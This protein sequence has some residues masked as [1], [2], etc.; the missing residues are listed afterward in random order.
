MK[1]NFFLSIVTIY[2]I[3]II[4]FSQSFE[5]VKSIGSNDDDKAFTLDYDDHG[6]IYIMGSFEGSIDIDPGPGVLTFTPQGYGWDSFL[7]K[8]DSAGNL[9]WGKHFQTNGYDHI[10]GWEIKLDGE[11]NI[12]VTGNFSGTVDFD[13]NTGIELITAQ[14][15]NDSFIAKLDSNGSLEWVHK[16]GGVNTNSNYSEYAKSLTI[17]DKANVYITGT[18]YGAVDFDPGTSSFIMSAPGNDV[19]RYV[20][21]LNSQGAFRW[22]F[23][24]GETRDFDGKH[25]CYDNNGGVLITGY[26][27]GTF[28]FDPGPNIFNLTSQNSIDD[29]FLLKVDTS[30]GFQW[31][32]S[33]G[34]ALSD[35]LFSLASD[36]QGNAIVGGRFRTNFTIGT[37]ILIGKIWDVFIGKYDSTGTFLWSGHVAANG[38]Y[39]DVSISG[40]Q[41]DTLSNMYVLGRFKGSIDANPNLGV[42]SLITTNPNAFVLKLNKD[43]TYM[44]TYTFGSGSFYFWQ[45]DLKIDKNFNTY[46]LGSFYEDNIDFD[47]GPGFATTAYKNDE[48]IF[49]S[50]L[51]CSV[52]QSAD[53]VSACNSFTW[54]DGNTYTQPVNGL[55]FSANSSKGC[56]S[57][58][59][60]Y[61]DM[62]DTS[63][64]KNQNTLIANETNASYQWLDCANGFSVLAGDTNQSYTPS[65]SGDYAVEITS[66]G[67]VDTSGCFHVGYIDIPEKV[68]GSVE[69]FPNPTNGSLQITNINLSNP[70]EK[71]KVYN[72]I[73]ELLEMVL[74]ESSTEVE[75]NIEGSK[76]LYI[77]QIEFDNGKVEN[78]KVS[79]T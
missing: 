38:T 54:I 42:D 39:S 61:L 67:C 40:I 29:C 20:L 58:V 1:L 44:S 4:G 12:Y 57:L 7:I 72:T 43:N 63:V 35:N 27:K 51:S 46:I 69:I 68:T 52:T 47:P 45:R 70:I 14:G 49:L 6:N 66:N 28:D 79:K 62:L 32:N 50:K 34:S 74:T 10:T 21:S 73:G 16:I 18:Y 64:T 30:G 31:A 37:N 17:D 23:D 60:L 36:K 15:I 65:I 8:L 71:V 53:S 9:I 59:T 22:A 48:D 33:F 25:I 55:L 13:P 19:N 26:F 5:W 2:L 41:T 56:D 11:K 77:I 76:G 78:Y 3:P 75:F 24:L